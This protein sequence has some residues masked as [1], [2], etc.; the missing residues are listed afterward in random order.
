MRIASTPGRQR[1]RLADMKNRLTKLK[2]PILLID[3]AI[4]R[5]ENQT[6]QRCV[7]TTNDARKMNFTF[8]YCE[9][10]SDMYNQRI[11]PFMSHMNNTIFR[12]NPISLRKCMRQSPNLLRSLNMHKYFSVSK[13]GKPRCKTCNVI[14]E[15]R[16]KF[17]KNGKT[18]IFNHNMNC[19]T[20]NVIYILSC[21]NCTS[22]YIG[23]T[24]TPLRLRVNTHRQHITHIHYTTLFVSHHIRECGSNFSIIPIYH[25]SNNSPYIIC[26]VEDYFISSFE[27]DLNRDI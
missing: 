4:Q 2:Y 14:T 10:N 9:Q 12:D 25:I 8:T 1:I 23:K 17:C 13:C 22:F 6:D 15:K 5:A 26:K 19:D 7:Q 21:N 16:N 24:N 11:V 18:V 20:K 3:N 27:P